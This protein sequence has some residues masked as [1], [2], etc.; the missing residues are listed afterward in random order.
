MFSNEKEKWDIKSQ[1]FPRYKDN[2]FQ[3]DIIKILQK[4]NYL[5]NEFTILDIGCGTGVYTI[6]LAK[7]AS[8]VIALDISSKMLKFLEED[9]KKEGVE[10]ISIK[11]STWEEFKNIPNSFDL[12]YASLTPAI[13]TEEDYNKMME[14]SQKYLAYLGWAGN[15]KSNIEILFNESHNIP[16]IDLNDAKP[17]KEYLLSKN[18]KHK[19]IQF[20]QTFQREMSIASATLYVQELMFANNGNMD[21]SVEEMYDTLTPLIQEEKV[22]FEL[23]G[24][25]ELILWEK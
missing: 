22:H 9:A 21:L 25:M 16:I 15:K 7:N 11:Y 5:K 8:K 20:N 19:I 6:E 4:E 14:T 3:K 13:R 24:D 18:I 12:V 17:L 10:N 2:T 1:N 23:N